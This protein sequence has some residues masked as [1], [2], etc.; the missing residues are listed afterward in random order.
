[1]QRESPDAAGELVLAAAEKVRLTVHNDEEPLTAGQ[2]SH[3]FERFHR[4]DS[5]RARELGGYG[6][7]LSIA[8]RIAGRHRGS[9]SAAS[10]REMGTSFTVLL[11]R[12]GRVPEI[13]LDN[14]KDLHYNAGKLFQGGV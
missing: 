6:L 8:Q 10:G 12:A 14:K 1:M 4:A 11:P 5:S 3:L 9:I 13:F 7:G 2:L